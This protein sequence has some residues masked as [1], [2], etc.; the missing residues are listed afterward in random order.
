MQLTTVASQ[1]HN[2]SHE[3]LLRSSHSTS[4]NNPSSSETF[5]VLIDSGCSVSCTGFKEDF[6]GKLPMG[7]FGYVNT[8]NGQ[9]KIDGFCMVK[10]DVVSL[11]G[12][13]RTIKIPVF[14]S[15]AVALRLLSPQDYCRYHNFDSSNHNYRGTSSWM[16]IDVKCSDDENDFSTETVLAHIAPD[17]RL[18]SCV[19]KEDTMKSMNQNKPVAIVMLHW[20]MMFAIRIFPLHRNDLSW[21][22][23]NL[24]IYPCSRFRNSTNPKTN[25]MPNFDG[26]PTSGLPCLLARNS[27]QL[28]CAIPV[29]EA[30]E[31]A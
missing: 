8:A 20:C 19:L 16:S 5:N 2:V 22:I 6:H 15:S 29:C 12:N 25:Q 18:P 7:N 28:K 30:C 17:S 9:A 11:D 10:W 27:A 3:H 23:M 1:N 26:H 31:L 13:C 4:T 14:F 21:I 24:G